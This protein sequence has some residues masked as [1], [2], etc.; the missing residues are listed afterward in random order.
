MFDDE[1]YDAEIQLDR[2]GHREFT[3]LDIAGILECA[4][5]TVLNYVNMGRFPRAAFIRE[6]NAAHYWTREQV[7]DIMT[8]PERPYTGR[9]RQHRN[10]HPCGTWQGCRRH[11]WHKEPVCDPC[12]LAMNEYKRGRYKLARLT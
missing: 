7:I 2:L 5:S 10:V 11:Q 1:R 8:H 6:G 12:R 3:S 4:R 9:R